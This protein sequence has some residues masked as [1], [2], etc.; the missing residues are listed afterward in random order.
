M[1]SVAASAL[2]GYSGDALVF[3][4]R[5]STAAG[6]SWTNV[7]KFS[8]TSGS[9]I[10]PSYTFL[11]A[12]AASTAAYDFEWDSTT[13]TL[14]VLDYTNRN[15]SIFSTAV[16]EPSTCAVLLASLGIG[17]ITALRRRR[18]NGPS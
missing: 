10:T 3:N 12:P 5:A 7:I 11:S 16:P 18:A 6:Q 9:L 15:V 2:N 1:N 8:T 14:A 13:Q 4:D 17:G